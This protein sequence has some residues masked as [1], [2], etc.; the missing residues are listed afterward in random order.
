LRQLI[1]SLNAFSFLAA[2]GWHLFVALGAVVL[3]FT[4]AE[5]LYARHGAFRSKRPIQWAWTGLVLPALAIHYMG[6][7]ALLMRDPSA[8]E[9]PFF[10]MFPEARPVPARWFWRRSQRG[11]RLFAS[12]DFRLP[13]SMTRQAMQLGL[14]PRMQVINTSAKRLARSTRPG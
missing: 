11:Y 4:G 1:L 14:L 13:P 2:Q 7:G 9:S 6:Q 8:L 12:R 5:A 10:R 3:A